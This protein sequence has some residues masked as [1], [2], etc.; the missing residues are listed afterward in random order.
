M[1]F[2]G[3]TLWALTEGLSY[4][5]GNAWNELDAA[6]PGV[7]RIDADANT[8]VL[9]LSTGG[10]LYRW[11]GEEMAN[12]G[13]PPNY[14]PQPDGDSAGFV[15]DIVV[16]ADSDVWAPG[17]NGYLPS[18]GA[19]AVYH[20]DSNSWETVR[21]WRSDEDIPAWSL[22]PTPDGGLWVMLSD[23]PEEGPE[24]TAPPPTRALAHRDSVTGN[25]TV[26]DEALPDGHALVM[27]A[28][29]DAVWLVQGDS[30][31]DDSEAAFRFTGGKWTQLPTDEPI[32]IAVA[33]DGTVWYTTTT[34]VLRQLE[35]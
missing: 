35:P 10:E 34:G 3:D 17:M 33:P 27:A 12:V 30:M 14:P 6:P 21:P 23:W 7:W 29:D 24:T 4:F 11:D 13:F 26:Y 32:D 2:D 5:D 8:G 9:W 18:L 16:T 25:W 1:A 31:D 20:D 22:A 19:L 28:T 15:G